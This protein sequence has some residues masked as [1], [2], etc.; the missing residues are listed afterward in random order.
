MQNLTLKQLVRELRQLKGKT[1]ISFHS[2]GDVDAVAS[3]FALS[4]LVKDS[5]V[6][7]IDSVNS[8]A[9]KVWGRL[10]L[11]LEPFRE[12]ELAAFENLI[13][14]DVSTPTLLGNMEKEI[15]RFGGN[16]IAI[17]HHSHNHPIHG[18]IYCDP[19]RSSC[20]EVVYDIYKE[21]RKKID[22][23]TAAFLALGIIS[24]TAYFKSA[25]KSAII[26]LG[27]CLR[28]SVMELQ[29]FYDLLSVRED[30]SEIIAL[31]E[32]VKRAKLERLGD[33]VIAESQVSAFELRSAAALVQLGIDF[34]VVVN[35][36]E[37]K[38]SAVKARTHMLR[39]LNVGRMM[40]EAARHCHGSGGGH[41]MVG[42]ANFLHGLDAF[43]AADKLMARVRE[44]VG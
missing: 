44:E 27:E 2:L 32:A 15:A 10:N 35:Q 9:R 31:V 17:D 36:K 23:G 29:E 7:R 43:M 6:R 11:K 4:R 30:P 21:A 34:A 5:Q 41:E 25:T 18:K 24:D 3:A 20:C 1:A 26:A 14:V 28:N 38:I 12:N 13:L 16:L 33:V 37:G 39:K 40:D 8:Q 19:G 22:R 42:G